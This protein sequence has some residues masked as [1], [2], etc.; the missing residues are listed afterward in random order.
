MNQSQIEFEIKLNFPAEKLPAMEALLVS[1]GALKRQHLQAA[2]I[3]TNDFLLSQSGLAFRLRKEG[4]RW[5]QTLKAR[6]SNELERLEH[7]VVVPHYGAGIPIWDISLHEAHPAGQILKRILDKKPSPVLQVLYETDIW[8]RSAKVRGRG[9]QLEYA[10]DQGVIRATSHVGSVHEI[11][12]LELEI[13][14]INGDPLVVLNH[15][16]MIVNRFKATI[17]TRSKAQRGTQLA[18]GLIASQLEKSKPISLSGKTQG[19]QLATLIYSCLSQI[20]SNASEINLEIENYDE[21][22]HQLRIGLRRLRILL[23]LL[24]LENIGLDSDDH[25]ALLK[26]FSELGVYRDFHFLK[27]KLLPKLILEGAPQFSLQQD[28]NLK[29][30]ATLTKEDKFQKLLISLMKMAMN[31][32]RSD[33]IEEGFQ[34][35]VLSYIQSIHR[36]SRKIAKKF[37]TVEDEKRHDLR[38]KLKQLRYLLE[39]FK[40]F[41]PSKKF[42]TYNKSLALVLDNLGEYNDLCIALDQVQELLVNDPKIWFVLGWLKSEKIHIKERSQ[43]SLDIFFKDKFIL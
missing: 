23:K 8:R 15:A 6:G 32:E 35:R 37:E 2:Y 22:V 4:R 41:Y 13:E 1:K 27:I 16:Q 19:Q 9:A 20:L 31:I 38:K 3:D 28:L 33:T 39:F 18:Q 21:Y 14:L 25:H 17:D 29:H 43:V 36:S 42:K 24:N 5:I 11:P 30:P 7:N 26:I 12:V 10:L 34:L 40:D